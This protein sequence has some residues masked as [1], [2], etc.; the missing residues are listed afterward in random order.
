M[1]Y[2]FLI[3]FLFLPLLAQ[4][5]DVDEELTVE[6]IVVDVRVLDR[7]GKPITDLTTDDLRLTSRG[8]DLEILSW[9]WVS[10]SAPMGSSRK[11]GGEVIDLATDEADDD[12]FWEPIKPGAKTELDGRIMVFFLQKDVGPDLTRFLQSAVLHLKEA[13]DSLSSSDYV[14]VFSYDFKLHLHMDLTRVNPLLAESLNDAATG[15]DVIDFGSGNGRGSFADLISRYD[16]DEAVNVEKALKVVGD[17]LGAFDG[18]KTM[19]FLGYGM[20]QRMTNRKVKK[21]AYDPAV[22]AL[23][24][25][26]TAV[27]VI[28]YFRRDVTADPNML[29]QLASD[30]G[31]FYR[32][33]QRQQTTVFQRTFEAASGYYQLVFAVPED[34]K[35]PKYRLKVTRKHRDLLVRKPINEENFTF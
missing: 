19:V 8:R 13:V 24:E 20:G 5:P 27:Y 17:A 10:G 31:G 6:R 35:N 3:S 34:Q 15:A 4:Q 12:A 1:R 29:Q 21:P 11:P 14:A 16:A 7:K 26:N 25:A 2:A 30:T 23:N 22:K 18:A 28:D 33:S 9:E 32:Q